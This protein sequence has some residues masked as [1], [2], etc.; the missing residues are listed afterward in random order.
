MEDVL[1]YCTDLAFE[2]DD[3]EAAL[4]FRQTI[5][6]RRIP[7]KELQRALIKADTAHTGYVDHKTF[8]KLFLRLC[9]GESFVKPDQLSDIKRYVDPL[10][11]GKMDIN[12]IV[13]MAI[14]CADVVRAENKLKNILKTMRVK[15]IDYRAIL[16]E[17]AGTYC[18]L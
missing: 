11:D 15:G 6:K 9:G 3:I 17:D 16:M 14:V 2:G 13:A 4:A 5:D 7:S 1:L 12:V 8:D 18:T 10:R